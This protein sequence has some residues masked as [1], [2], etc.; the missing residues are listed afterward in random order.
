MLTVGPR[1][2]STIRGNTGAC[3]YGDDADHQAGKDNI[4]DN[5]GHDD[6]GPS[7]PGT[8]AGM[9]YQQDDRCVDEYDTGLRGSRKPF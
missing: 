8:I 3:E 7:C 2:T 6:S 1:Q 5:K 4:K 9:L